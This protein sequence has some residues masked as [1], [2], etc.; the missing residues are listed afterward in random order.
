MPWL[1]RPASVAL[2]LRFRSVRSTADRL[3]HQAAP[4]A[5]SSPLSFAS[6]PVAIDSFRLLTWRSITSSYE[7][8]EYTLRSHSPSGGGAC[9]ETVPGGKSSEAVRYPAGASASTPPLRDG[10]AHACTA[11]RA[12]SAS[13]PAHP[14]P[15][16]ASHQSL[17]SLPKLHDPSQQRW[18]STT[19]AYSCTRPGVS[20]SRPAEHWGTRHAGVPY[21]YRPC[22]ARSPSL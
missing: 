8:S 9:G 21:M 18:P 12:R 6:P 11:V 14:S 22:T 4:R 19:E 20:F 13:H 17:D 1:E 15:P 3:L 7:P 5:P 16:P 2:F 10:T